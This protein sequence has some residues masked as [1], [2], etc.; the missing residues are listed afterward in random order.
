MLSSNS[1]STLQGIVYDGGVRAAR[2][3][4]DMSFWDQLKS[5]VK[6]HPIGKIVSKRL[7]GYSLIEH[8]Y[9]GQ[10]QTVPMWNRGPNKRRWVYEAIKQYGEDYNDSDDRENLITP[11]Q[12]RQGLKMSFSD[13]RNIIVGTCKHISYSFLHFKA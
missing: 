10:F 13:M 11:E 2:E 8:T 4:H 7:N 12:V 1:P 3:E 5:K 6:S 9:E